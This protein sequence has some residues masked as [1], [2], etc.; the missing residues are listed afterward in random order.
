[1]KKNLQVLV[2]GLIARGYTLCTGGSDTH[3]LLWDVRP[4][5]L[6]GSKLEKLFEI[7]SISVN[8]NTIPGDASAI[9]PGGVRLGSPSLTSRN[10][11]EKDFEQVVEFLDRGVK[12]AQKIQEKHGKLLKNFIAALAT[13]EDLKQLKHDVEEFSSKFPIPG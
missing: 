11:G 10:F 2:A 5:G 8:K 12:I 4:Q 3:L 13:D 6:T 7:C 9:S 1:V